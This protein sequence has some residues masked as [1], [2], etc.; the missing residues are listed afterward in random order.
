MAVYVE[1]QKQSLFGEAIRDSNI[2]EKQPENRMFIS[3]DLSSYNLPEEFLKKDKKEIPDFWKGILFTTFC[4]ALFVVMTLLLGLSLG[5]ED[6]QYDPPQTFFVSEGIERNISHS[7]DTEHDLEC[8]DIDIRT[9]SPNTDFYTNCWQDRQQIENS[10]IAPLMMYERDIEIGVLDFNASTLEVSLPFTFSNNSNISFIMGT[11]AEPAPII[12]SFIVNES[13]TAS[14]FLV[15]LPEYL[16]AD[17][18]NFR[19]QIINSN[20]IEEYN[21][22]VNQGND[23]WY[24]ESKCTFYIG[25]ESEIGFIDLKSKILMMSLEIPLEKGSYLEIE[26]DHWNNGEEEI[27]FLFLWIPPI[28][29]TIGV[30][31]MAYNKNMLMAGGASAG[32]IPVV[33]LTSIISAIIIEGFL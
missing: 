28:F 12:T 5:L 14:S 11:R 18:L 25:M 2:L 33:I 13:D 27:I 30:I 10:G 9:N 24:Y 7:L 4:G 8:Y 16:Y 32:I 22:W 6:E 29:F 26:Y 19:I 31:M 15:S 17:Q 20:G 3:G 21:E 1:G 23:C